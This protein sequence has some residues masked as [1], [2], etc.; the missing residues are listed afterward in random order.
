MVLGRYY[1]VVPKLTVKPLLLGLKIYWLLLAL[2]LILI[3]PYQHIAN[4][5]HTFYQALVIGSSASTHM[6]VSDLALIFFQQLSEYIANPIIS[7]F[8]YKLCLLR[9]TQSATGLFYVMVFF[10]LISEMLS[11]YLLYTKGFRI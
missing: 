9:S 5:W 2:K 6:D 4:F 8:A 1:L 10:A 7:Y 3:Y 11:L